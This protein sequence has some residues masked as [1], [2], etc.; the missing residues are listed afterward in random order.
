MKNIP[1]ILMIFALAVFTGVAVTG[2]KDSAKKSDDV[3]DDVGSGKKKNVGAASPLE[4]LKIEEGAKI[5]GSVKYKGTPPAVVDDDRIAKHGSDKTYCM[6]GGGMHS[7]QQTWFVNADNTVQNILVFLAPPKGKKFAKT[8]TQQTAKIVSDQPF[9]NFMPHVI[10]VQSDITP[11]VFKNSS[12]IAHNVSIPAI[13]IN[14]PL[15]PK[16]ESDEYKFKGK[17]GLLLDMSCSSHTWMLAKI[18]VFEHPYFAVTDDKGN[19][20][21]KNA[22]VGVDLVLHYWHESFGGIGDKKGLAAK[23]YQKGDNKVEI[24][25]P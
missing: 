8:S 22:P 7:K 25:L 6:S 5:F 16:S 9:C 13:D 12:A 4:E 15:G 21:I 19:F 23:S 14:R 3:P 17:S 11:V 1:I 18:S 24:E 10:A 2:C 20:E